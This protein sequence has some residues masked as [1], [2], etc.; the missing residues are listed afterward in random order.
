MIYHADALLELMPEWVRQGLGQPT[1]LRELR[2][3]VGQAP[4]VCE[5]AGVRMLPGRQVRQ[6]DLTYI[7][8]TASRY[9]PYAASGLTSGYITARGGHR[10]GICG[11]GIC[12][13]GSIAGIKELRSLCIRAARDMPGIA[14]GLPQKIGTG[15]VLILGP[16]GSGK[17]TLLR[18]LI[19]CL[20][21]EGSQVG[22]VDERCELFPTEPGGFCFFP[23]PCT[24]VLS[25]V[26]KQSGIEMLLR[27]MG[28]QWIALDEITSEADCTI[29]ERAGYCGVQFLAACHG[30]NKEDLF[31][32]PVYRK[33][34]EARIFKQLILMTRDQSFTLEEMEQ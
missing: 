1:E 17:T 10:I 8:N 24:D 29:M 25:G 18:D 30:E 2:L 3:R 19:R 33:L 28:P 14:S 15:S 21:R 12:K 22:V 4:Q 5:K 16:P 9:S 34:M 32:R 7:I 27:S 11:T 31:R 6:E 20:S 23:G 13:S 26:G